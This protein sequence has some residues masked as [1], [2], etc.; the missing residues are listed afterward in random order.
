MT[1]A[2]IQARGIEIAKADE[3]PGL[4]ELQAAMGALKVAIAKIET[5][6]ADL[7]T[8][9]KT[10]FLAHVEAGGDM[11]IV[12]WIQFKRT[13]KF[14]YDPKHALQ[15]VKENGLPYTRTTFSLDT[16]PFKRDCLDGTVDYVDGEKVNTPQVA[17]GALGDLLI[18]GVTKM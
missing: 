3:C 13:E 5:V 17:I 11:K 4:K 8:K 2:Q 6:P 1:E 18:I 9:L 7:R 15:F 10:D 14:E 12:P 16:V